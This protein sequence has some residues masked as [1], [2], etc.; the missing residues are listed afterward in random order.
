MVI[1]LYGAMRFGKPFGARVNWNLELPRET[2]GDGLLAGFGSELGAW[3][4]GTFCAEAWG[5]VPKAIKAASR[6]AISGRAYSFIMC[7]Y[8]LK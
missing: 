1:G 7:A 4:P 3:E 2:V 5:K 6:V 8:P